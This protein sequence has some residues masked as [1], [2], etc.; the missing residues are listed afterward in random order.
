MRNMKNIFFFCIVALSTAC[1]QTTEPVVSED[2]SQYGDLITAENVI[3][4]EALL[5]ELGDQKEVSNVKVEGKVE[6]VCQ[7][8]G[9]W[10][11]IVSEKDAT[12]EP[13]FVK[14]KDYGIF[15]PKD[16][17]G[18]TVI[19]HGKAFKEETSIEEL[20]HYAED[21]GKSKEEI[22][23]ITEPKVELKFLADAVLVPNSGK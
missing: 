18:S 12:L 9:C 17:A 15:M 14:F 7:A 5:K 13:M 10:M 16:L 20:R 22:E 2:G 8:K 6:G 19:M 11:N 4:Y 23:A 1:A 3:S 21:E